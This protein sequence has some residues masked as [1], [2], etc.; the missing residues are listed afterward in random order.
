MTLRPY[1][2]M[3]LLHISRYDAVGTPVILSFVYAGLCGP[4]GNKKCAAP[5]ETFIVR[6]QG[7]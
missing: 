4:V 5:A 6:L 7:R 1:L 2:D 3:Q